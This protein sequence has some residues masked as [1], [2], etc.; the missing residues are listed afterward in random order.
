MRAAGEENPPTTEKYERAENPLDHNIRA[1][2]KIAVDFN[3][4]HR[5]HRQQQQRDGPKRGPPEPPIHGGEFC[6]VFLGRHALRF[7]IHATDRTTAGPQ[8]F[9]LG[10]H[11]TGIDYLL[12]FRLCYRSWFF[13]T[14]RRIGIAV[15][16]GEKLFA[17][18]RAAKI[19]LL[20]LLASR[21]GPFVRPPPCH[22]SGRLPYENA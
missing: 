19:E 8:L 20:F 6:R 14:G 5:Q 4:Q 7:Q 18:V 3:A 15:G 12:A 2:R 11:G 21:K 13:V 16:P 22:R 1:M 17:A 9:D 10:V